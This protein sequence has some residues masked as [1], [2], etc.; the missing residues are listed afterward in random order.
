MAASTTITLPNK[1]KDWAQTQASLGGFESVD[2]FVGHVLQDERQ[3]QARE[4]LELKLLEAINSGPSC[5][6]TESDWKQLKQLARHGKP[7]ATRNGSHR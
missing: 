2:E 3:R 7:H 4:S 5:P 6:M 1:L